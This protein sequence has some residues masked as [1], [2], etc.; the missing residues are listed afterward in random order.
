VKS[1]DVPNLS[2]PIWPS[3]L[4]RVAAQ[5]DRARNVAIRLE[6]ENAEVTDLVRALVVDLREMHEV[7]AID[8]DRWP[9]AR[10]LVE[11]SDR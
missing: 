1:I 6:Q 4:T 2:K 3:A 9:A 7:Q 10:H 11:W 8:L 5:R